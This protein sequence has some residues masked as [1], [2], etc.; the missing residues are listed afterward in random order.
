MQIADR[1]DIGVG[2][3]GSATGSGLGGEG[4]GIYDQGKAGTIGTLVID[5]EVNDGFTGNDGASERP[6]MGG[7]FGPVGLSHGTRLTG[8][9]VGS[10]FPEGAEDFT[11]GRVGQ[12][13]AQVERDDNDS[14]GSFPDHQIELPVE[15]FAGSD[16]GDLGEFGFLT[17]RDIADE[18]V[19]TGGNGSRFE[20]KPAFGGFEAVLKTS[21]GVVE[22]DVV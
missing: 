6:V 18:E 22:E 16:F 1:G 13:D 10:G 17:I 4:Q 5:F 20:F 12:F 15:G 19:D 2:G 3:D 11:R 14:D 7:E 21:R 9:K 8:E